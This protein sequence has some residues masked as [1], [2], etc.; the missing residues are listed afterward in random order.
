MPEPAQ[1]Q[2]VGPSLLTDAEVFIVRCFYYCDKTPAAISSLT[3]L[4]VQTGTF[5]GVDVYAMTHDPAFVSNSN[6][7][8]WRLFAAT[9]GTE[10]MTSAEKVRRVCNVQCN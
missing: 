4:V 6:Q 2:R 8:K 10:I 1:V 3:A 9:K 5:T 7:R